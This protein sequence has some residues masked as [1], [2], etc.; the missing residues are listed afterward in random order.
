MV[1]EPVETKS[2]IKKAG[3][4]GGN[5]APQKKENMK[6]NNTNWKSLYTSLLIITFL[7]IIAML[8]F[9]IYYK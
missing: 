8:I 2:L 7:M 4:E 6:E 9:Q 1:V 3:A 5:L